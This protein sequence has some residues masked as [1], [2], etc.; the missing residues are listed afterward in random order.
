[1]GMEFAPKLSSAID[2]REVTLEENRWVFSEPTGVA[3]ASRFVAT[4]SESQISV[5]A[6]LPTDAKERFETRASV[7]FNEFYRAFQPAIILASSA[8]IRATLQIDGDARTFL[9]THVTKFDETRLRHLGRPIHL[10]GLRLFMPPVQ[11]Q[12]K[13]KGKKGGKAARAEQSANWMVDVK[14]ESLLEDT[15][16]LFLEADARWQPPVA[17][18]DSTASKIVER[19]GVVSEFVNEH[20][21]PFLKGE[22]E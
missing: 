7:I 18:D 22:A 4:V 2:A 16:K 5:E 19:L 10:F 14:A 17:W 12:Q 13:S 1:M 9:S 8:L 11:Q 20:F 3:A 6:V 21:I 15:S